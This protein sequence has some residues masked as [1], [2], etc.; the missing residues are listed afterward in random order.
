MA[1]SRVDFPEPFG[2]DES[3]DGTSRDGERRFGERH[4]LAV[5]ERHPSGHDGTQ[6]HSAHRP[7]ISRVWPPGWKPARPA[8]APTRPAM[9]PSSD[10]AHRNV[11][12][13][14]AFGAHQVV[15]MSGSHSAGSCG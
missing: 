13:A 14:A 4:R 3:G 10:R 12:D 9:R 2:S 15:V 8:I 7:S 1:W 11:F 5:P 6:A